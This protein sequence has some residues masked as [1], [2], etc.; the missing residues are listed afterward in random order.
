MGLLLQSL[1]G[2]QL[3]QAIWLRF[4]TSTG[5]SL[6]LTLLTSKLE[7]RSDSQLVVGKIQGEYESKD[8]C[9]AWYLSKV[10]TSLD[11]LSKWVI[12]RIPA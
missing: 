2:E 3:E 5:L 7:I 1:T 11:K 9:M 10:Q 8:E 4:P 12:K 6:V